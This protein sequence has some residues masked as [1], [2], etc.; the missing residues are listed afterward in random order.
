[1]ISVLIPNDLEISRIYKYKGFFCCDAEALQAAKERESK[2]LA[3]KFSLLSEPSN[4]L[5][6]CSQ[7]LFD[8]LNQ[9]L[10]ILEINFPLHFEL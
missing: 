9:Y 1:M 8:L 7:T 4:S 5:I 6:V 3:P 2:M 10:L